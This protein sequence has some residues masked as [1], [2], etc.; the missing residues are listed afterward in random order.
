MTDVRHV[1]GRQG[2]DFASDHYKRLG[3]DVLARNHRTRFGE[4]DLVVFDGFTLVF[5]EV[6]TRRS[7]TREPWENLHD[8]KQSQVRKMAMV[9]LGD[10]ANRPRFGQLR[11]DGVAIQLDAAGDLVRLDHLEAAF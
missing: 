2:E 9:W 11:F 7:G 6:K 10:P 5:V 3:Y 8:R 4:L 1:A